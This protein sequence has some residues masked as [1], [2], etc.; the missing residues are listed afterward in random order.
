MEQ[1]LKQLP[2]NELEKID[3]NQRLLW[4]LL[5]KLKRVVD[6]I[7]DESKGLQL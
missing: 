3:F 7:D 2:E 1:K 4:R 5:Q 6:F